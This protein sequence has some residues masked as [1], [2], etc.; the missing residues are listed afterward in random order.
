MLEDVKQFANAGDYSA[1][2]SALADDYTA[3][4]DRGT[5]LRV[6]RGLDWKV[7]TIEIG[8]VTVHKGIAYAPVRALSIAGRQEIRVYTVV[9]WKRYEGGWKML[10]FPFLNPHLPDYGSIP[11]GLR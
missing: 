3:V 6:C 2:Y 7:R 4:V 11:E 9:F 1:I 8:K 5:F 10:N